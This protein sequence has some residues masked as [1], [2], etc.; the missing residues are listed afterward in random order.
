MVKLM[1]LFQGLVNFVLTVI[2]TT[3]QNL[4]GII[5]YEG[6]LLFCYINPCKLNMFS[7]LLVR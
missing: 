6:L 4:G 2:I 7:G 1:G 3:L 5:K